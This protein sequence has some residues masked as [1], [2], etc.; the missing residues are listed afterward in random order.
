MVFRMFGMLLTALDIFG[1]N[2]GVQYR[3]QE[4]YKTKFGGLLTLATYVLVLIQTANLIDS[5][6]NHTEQVEN[7]VRIK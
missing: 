7:F 6:V 4:T 1:H 2:V 5:F 3:G